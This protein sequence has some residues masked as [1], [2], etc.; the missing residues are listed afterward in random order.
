MPL[1]GILGLITLGL[2]RLRRGERGHKEAFDEA[3]AL[4]EGQFELQYLA[5]VAAA[6]AEA[7]WLTGNAHRVD[8]E[9]RDVVQNEYIRRVEKVNGQLY[10]VEFATIEAVRDPMKARK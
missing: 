2:V 3:A 10:N 7:A 8:A 9:T 6:R 1:L 5:P 4:C